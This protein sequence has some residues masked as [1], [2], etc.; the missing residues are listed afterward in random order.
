MK[1]TTR[2]KAFCHSKRK[3][4]E[5]HSVK[6]TWN[7]VDF[8]M[9]NSSNPFASVKLV[10]LACVWKADY[11]R[12]C[13]GFPVWNVSNLLFFLPQD[14]SAW[15]FFRYKIQFVSHQ[16]RSPELSSL[17]FLKFALFRC[18]II[19]LNV[20]RVPPHC[21]LMMFNVVNSSTSLKFHQSWGGVAR[22][23][24]EH[25]LS[26]NYN[27]SQ[28]SWWRGNPGRFF[29]VHKS[30]DWRNV[31]AEQLPFDHVFD[32]NEDLNV[33][34]MSDELMSIWNFSSNTQQQHNKAAD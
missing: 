26:F 14:I 3:P 29:L 9:S 5:R 13:S 25:F 1:A 10:F 17:K 19:F 33:L 8:L 12:L 4:N 6:K 30:L 16:W 24:S 22:G 32:V 21:L 20:H 34:Y 15:M 27:F 18:R 23:E 11:T 2:V 28:L 7:L 31:S